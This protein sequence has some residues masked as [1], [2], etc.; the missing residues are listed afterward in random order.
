MLLW[1]CLKFPHP[2]EAH[3]DTLRDETLRC[4]GLCGQA[5]S[6]APAGSPAAPQ[7]V[8]GESPELAVCRRGLAR[9]WS[10]L[11]G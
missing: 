6:G 4:P 8:L 9:S 1:L 11:S 3:T 10:W 5:G 7:S 2:L